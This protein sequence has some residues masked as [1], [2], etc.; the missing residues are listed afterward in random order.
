MLL[1]EEA[2]DA[3][4]RY[5][6]GDSKAFTQLYQVCYHI[7]RIRLCKLIKNYRVLYQNDLNDRCND[8]VMDLL[9]RYKGDKKN[10]RIS[11]GGDSIYVIKNFNKILDYQ[12]KKS[13][14]YNGDKRY[15]RNRK[16]FIE[17]STEIIE[18]LPNKELLDKIEIMEEFEE[19]SKEEKT[20]IFILNRYKSYGIAIKR[21][22]KI[23][24]KRWIYDRAVL[25][26][27]IYKLL[28]PEY[29]MRKVK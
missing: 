7:M 13:L 1:E 11:R 14:F 24:G 19:L 29:L 20:I 22:E 18:E 5:L 4:R 8:G 3:Q 23:K 17:V 15:V 16:E 28:H 26:H 9:E 27:R 25:L 6:G 10:R 2:R 21:I 12:A